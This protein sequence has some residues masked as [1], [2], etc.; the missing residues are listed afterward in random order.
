MR[1]LDSCSYFGFAVGV[2][3]IEA[4]QLQNDPPVDEFRRCVVT[5]GIRSD[6]TWFRR[7]N[8]INLSLRR[9]WGAMHRV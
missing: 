6:T 1:S 4:T 5:T 7:R 3:Y 9:V 2:L 8:Y